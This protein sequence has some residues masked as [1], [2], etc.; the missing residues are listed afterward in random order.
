MRQTRDLR[1]QS[2]ETPYLCFDSRLTFFLYLA[3]THQC[4]FCDS[5]YLMKKLADL[6]LEPGSAFLNPIED[7][8]LNPSTV[9][10]D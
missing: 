1:F 7:V 2:I 6:H 5:A 9:S 10:L 8:A 3:S 4:F